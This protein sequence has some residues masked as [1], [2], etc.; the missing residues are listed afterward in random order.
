MFCGGGGWCLSEEA[1]AL[2][3]CFFLLDAT[4]VTQV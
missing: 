1:V 3:G 2:L 4:S